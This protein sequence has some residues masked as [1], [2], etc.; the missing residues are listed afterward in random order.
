[1]ERCGYGGWTIL[2]SHWP[3][4]WSFAAKLDPSINSPDSSQGDNRLAKI[5]WVVAPG[6]E[7]GDPPKTESEPIPLRYVHTSTD[8]LCPCEYQ[9]N[10]V[11]S[12]SQQTK[13]KILVHSWAKSHH[14][15]RAFSLSV[16]QPETITKYYLKSPHTQTQ[17]EEPTP[18]LKNA[19]TK[20][21][22]EKEDCIRTRGFS[23]TFPSVP[24]QCELGLTPSES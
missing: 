16:L 2:T 19:S 14:V 10:S 18:S 5:L 24:N 4:I 3:P 22:P 17:L 21:S 8:Y 9:S 6:L 11:T 1:M 13:A 7:P 20:K 23:V 12:K 15:A